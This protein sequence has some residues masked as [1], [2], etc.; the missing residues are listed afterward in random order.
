MF[1]V[2]VAMFP[3]FAAM[4]RAF[5]TDY[6]FGAA[7]DVES[8]REVRDARDPLDSYDPDILPSRAACTA[9]CRPVR[10]RL[11]RGHGAR[12]VRRR[13]TWRDRHTHQ[14]GNGRVGD[15]DDD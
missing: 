6:Q 15:E 12:P 13:S 11:C 7:S 14:H 2:F 10:Y 3:V 1:R 5:L 4:F 8:P 9:R